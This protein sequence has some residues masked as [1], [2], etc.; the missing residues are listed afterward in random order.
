MATG[1]ELSAA[2]ARA[3]RVA[4]RVRD[5]EAAGEGARHPLLRRHPESGRVAL[6]VS[7]RERLVAARR[8]GRRLAGTEAEALIDAVHAQASGGVPVRRHRWR[9][10][11]LLLT[12]NRSTLHA[13][14]HSAVVGTRTLHRVMVRGERPIAA[15]PRRRLRA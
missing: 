9:A 5:P 3:A 1:D 11:Q 2:L 10:G 15:G 4:A 14:D 8:D 7:A 6:Y 13:A 12:D